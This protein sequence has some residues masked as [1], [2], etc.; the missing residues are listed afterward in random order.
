MEKIMTINLRP[1]VGN[2]TEKEMAFLHGIQHG[3]WRPECPPVKARLAV[4][5]Y[6]NVLYTRRWDAGIDLEKLAHKCRA[7]LCSM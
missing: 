2:T 5:N 1:G 7:L 3:H 6:L 4:Q